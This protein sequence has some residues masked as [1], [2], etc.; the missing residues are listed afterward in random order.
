MKQLPVFR[1]VAA[2]WTLVN[3]PSAKREWSL[4]RK[5]GAIQEAGF[6]GITAKLTPE[7][8]KLAE[9]LGLYAVGG[10]SSNVPAD[11]SKLLQENRDNGARY[12]NVHLGRHDTLTPEALRQVLRLRREAKKLKVEFA[13]ETHRNT[14]T[15]TPEKVFALADAYHKATGELMPFC[16]DFSHLAVVK[17]LQPIH[18]SDRLLFRPDL[19][20]RAQLF[21]LRPFN[22]HH[23]QIPVTDLHG[24]LTAEIR[25]V[26]RPFLDRIFEVWLSGAQPAG[27]EIM[28][29]PELGSVSGGYNLST[30]PKTWEDTK[31]LKGVIERAW[32]KALKIH[33]ARS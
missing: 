1:Q 19:V 15:E 18:F 13:V 12:I 30:L 32:R 33:L 21:H 14:C 24:R 10:I 26:W 27:R 17:H 8:R 7:H 28:V 16:W 20:Q 23:A 5:M 9:K 3:Y 11:F 2:L 22:G 4:E 25:N 29:C 31:V 6:D